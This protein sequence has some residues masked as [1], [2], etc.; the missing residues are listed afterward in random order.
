MRCV[1]VEAQRCCPSSTLHATIS[2]HVNNAMV[3]RR[4]IDVP[5]MVEGYSSSDRNAEALSSFR[6]LMASLGLNERANFHFFVKDVR[7][8]SVEA[9]FMQFAQVLSLCTDTS[10]AHVRSDDDDCTDF[11]CTI[12]G[13]REAAVGSGWVLDVRVLAGFGCYRLYPEDAQN[14]KPVADRLSFHR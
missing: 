1:R 4:K 11:A 10:P 13:L 14:D 6:M 12:D 7:D 3:Y 9:R 8:E 5:F 2:K